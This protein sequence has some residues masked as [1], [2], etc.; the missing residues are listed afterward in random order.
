[1]EN[2]LQQING[3]GKV[4]PGKIIEKWLVGGWALPLWKMME[5]KSVGMMTV[6]T[7]W[8]KKHVWIAL[9]TVFATNSSR[10]LSQGR[11]EP[12]ATRGNYGA[13][14]Q[15]TSLSQWFSS[16]LWLPNGMMMM[17]SRWWSLDG[18]KGDVCFFNCPP[19]GNAAQP[20]W[21]SELVCGWAIHQKNTN[22]NT[23]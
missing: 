8:K 3:V 22:E 11:F 21:A 7:E 23:S 13:R 16:H 6:P 19:N 20:K 15:M 18:L 4:C 17:L 12:K 9:G 14:V 5:L 2:A 10:A 1:M